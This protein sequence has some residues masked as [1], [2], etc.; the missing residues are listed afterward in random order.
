MAKAHA[1]DFNLKT[2]IVHI[3]WPTVVAYKMAR[4]IRIVKLSA[5]AKSGKPPPPSYGFHTTRII[6]IPVTFL[7]CWRV[8]LALSCSFLKQ[9][10]W[11]AGCSRLSEQSWLVFNS[12]A[13]VLFKAT[14]LQRFYPFVFRIHKFY[15]ALKFLIKTNKILYDQQQNLNTM[16]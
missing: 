13:L 1:F 2:Q 8:A 7:W 12:H 9:S 3:T 10:R 14:F 5:W 11:Y 16:P 4:T 15:S 6:M